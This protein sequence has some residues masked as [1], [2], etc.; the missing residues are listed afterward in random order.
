VIIL[1]GTA[2]VPDIV[3]NTVVSGMIIST[4]AAIKKEFEK[5]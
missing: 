3:A 2:A 4:P 1:G 5:M